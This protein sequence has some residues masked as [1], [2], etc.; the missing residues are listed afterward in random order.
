MSAAPD[1]YRF[2]LTRAVAPAA[3]ILGAWSAAL[4]PLQLTTLPPGPARPIAILAGVSALVLLGLAAVWRRRPP[5]AREVDRCIAL[6]CAIVLA[7]NVNV[8]AR[9]PTPSST[10]GLF[11]LIGAL[12]LVGIRGAWYAGLLG[13]TVLGFAVGPLRSG[14]ATEWIPASLALCGACVGATAVHVVNARFRR[15]ISELSHQSE[16]RRRAVEESL[17]RFKEEAEQRERLQQR[18]A[19]TARLE[20]LSHLA[21]GVANDFN[22]L[23]A[24]VVG[25]ADLGLAHART[26]E[27][28]AEL[29]NV[30]DAAERASLLAGELLTYAGQ[31][32]RK[33]STLDLSFLVRDACEFA[34]ES[35]PGGVSIALAMMQ[36][37]VR[38]AGDRAQLER[39]VQGLLHNAIEA[40]ASARSEIRVSVGTRSLDA[41]AASALEPPA[42][43]PGG[44]YAFLRV[45]DRGAGMAPETLAHVF[46]P[47]FTTREAG[48]GLG[49][50]AALGI[51]RAHGGGFQVASELARG[52]V[53]TAYFPL[54]TPTPA[55]PA[56]ALASGESVLVIDDEDGVRAMAAATLREAGY[57][58]LEA[59][60]GSAGLGLLRQ[61]A[62]AIGVAVLDMTMPDL[63]G[64][65]TFNAL[66]ELR[67]GLPVVLSS[68]FEAQ[69][70]AA[71][72]LELPGVRFLAKPY[73]TS[74]LLRAIAESLDAGAQA[75][76][77]RA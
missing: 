69:Q 23:M 24:V 32:E 37:A 7:N 19:R 39:V 65:D 48:R 13:L 3:A 2:A 22:N 29:Q 30:I 72:L 34:R 49:L 35:S 41:D 50:A 56:P 53:F 26:P 27:R 42:S 76:R 36:G 70:I 21:A 45:A 71:S 28:R 25:N 31:R 8:L 15:R 57:R 16:E 1:E 17:A 38:V 43:R 14:F 66:R 20:S 52:T 73:R 40:S 55:P 67:P 58:V 60:S 59:S 44:E 74:E 18:L 64:R 11:L 62:G 4:V 5:P 75:L 10:T 46:D 63:S 47:F 77:P 68:G 51:V 12:G 6:L 33:L 54:H 9:L 61:A